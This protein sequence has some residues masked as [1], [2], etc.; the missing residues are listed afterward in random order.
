MW[1][2]EIRAMA[3]THA[4]IAA[5]VFMATVVPAAL[6]RGFSVYGTHLPWLY[7][8][9]GAVAAVSVA[10]FWL[11]G[12]SPPTKK[13]TLGYKICLGDILPRCAADL[14]NHTEVPLC[15]R[16]KRPGLDT[17][18]QPA[19]SDVC[20]GHLSADNSGLHFGG[21]LGRSLSHTTGLGQALAGLARFLQS[22]SYY[23]LPDRPGCSSCVDPLPSQAAH[24][25]V[26]VM[27][28]MYACLQPHGYFSRIPGV[29]LLTLY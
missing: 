13:H 19:R 4:I 3:S 29:F 25:Q 1:D 28:V 5:S 16:P 21:S 6:V 27:D 7:A 15:P 14:F 26:Q 18:I 11:L 23:R 10:A 8:V 2:H 20:V 17:S 22:G 24:V 12:I 9:S